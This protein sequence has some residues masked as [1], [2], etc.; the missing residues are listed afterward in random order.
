[1]CASDEVEERW[2]RGR[3]ERCS[4]RGQ[5]QRVIYGGTAES[6]RVVVS[7]RAKADVTEA[8]RA[9]AVATGLGGLGRAVAP[10]RAD[11]S[12]LKVKSEH[13]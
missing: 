13:L 10:G 11:G 5:P 8:R 2:Q 7:T 9:I 12:E 4:S 3:V 6:H 1:M